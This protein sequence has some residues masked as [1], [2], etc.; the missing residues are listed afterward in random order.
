M[1]RIRNTVTGEIYEGSGD[2]PEGYEVVSG[3]SPQSVG[4]P[5]RGM[6]PEQAQRFAPAGGVN[7]GSLGAMIPPALGGIAGGALGGALAGPTVGCIP[8]GVMGGEALGS[9][10]GTA[11]N[12]AV[13]LEPPSL[14]QIG[15]SAALG[16]AARVAGGIGRGAMALGGRVLPGSSAARHLAAVDVMQGIPGLI[17]AKTPSAT[18]YADVA[19]LNPTISTAPVEAVID[20][21]AKRNA[22]LTPGLTRDEVDTV[23]AGLKS[24]MHPKPTPPIPPQAG[25]RPGGMPP[26]PP[27]TTSNT[28]P[29]MSFQDFWERMRALREK[30]ESMG[31]SKIIGT[32]ELKNLRKAMLETL[33]NAASQPGLT[34][35]A[36]SKL[37][38]ANAM[39][40]KEVAHD[41]VQEFVTTK[42]ISAR[43]GDNML[44][45]KPGLVME[46]LR[47]DPD[48]VVRLLDPG[49]RAAIEATMKKLARLPALPPPSGVQ[50]GSGRT[51]ARATVG[52]A[53]GLLGGQS[54]EAAAVGMAVA[55]YG[56]QLISQALM[57]ERGRHLLLKV[58]D[59][60]P[61]LDWPRLATLATALRAPILADESGMFP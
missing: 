50:F 48:D 31:A 39:F 12:Q 3:Q 42:G 57:T 44:H 20:E 19:A 7:W 10:A 24:A 56:P 34:G 6:T 28:P 51:L 43:A 38:A 55:G 17:R 21:I 46:W 27:A 22:R 32:G 40:R 5:P 14:N 8:L 25:F 61:F 58:M 45:V 60:G 2:I 54:Q 47:K 52:G 18:L 11:F 29:E 13:G 41:A 30:I 37:R 23:I 1:T 53:V 9:A 16:P 33:D 15:L 36:A 4:A 49:E 59:R 26:A 35:E